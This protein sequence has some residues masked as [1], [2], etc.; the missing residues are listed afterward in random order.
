MLTKHV[1]YLGTKVFRDHS[2][3][4]WLPGE[5]RQLP[6]RAAGQLLRHA[7]FQTL[8]LAEHAYQWDMSSMAGAW[9]MFNQGDSNEVKG[10]SFVANA[11]ARNGTALLIKTAAASNERKKVRTL[12]SFGAGTFRWR[13]YVSDLS[14]NDQCSI[15]CWLY[16]DDTHEL[17]FEIYHGKAADRLRLGARADEVIVLLSSQ[18]LPEYRHELLIKKNAWHDFEI[19]LELVN[20]VEG[21]V[22]KVKWGI[23]GVQVGQTVEMY[24]GQGHPFHIY[25]SVENLTFTGDHLPTK[26]NYALFDSVSYTPKVNSREPFRFVQ[27]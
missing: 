8:A 6:L 26:E 16:K 19:D 24:F 11:E 13:A 1:V 21:W 20:T 17:D 4:T 3:N 7:E 22:Y 10:H 25:C 5:A 18:A 12:L 2:G 23:D 15:G 27:P 9:E 14:N